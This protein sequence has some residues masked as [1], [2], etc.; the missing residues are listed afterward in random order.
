MDAVAPIE[1]IRISSI[2]PN[3][4]KGETIVFVVNSKRF[5]PHFHISLQSGS[6]PILKKN[7][8]ATNCV[9]RRGK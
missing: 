3:L 2:E 9:V 7:R 1:R 4:L 5:V 6:A 8:Y